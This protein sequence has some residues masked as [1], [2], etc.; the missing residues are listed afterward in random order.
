MASNLFEE[1]VPHLEVT[2]ARVL[3]SRVPNESTKS[4]NPQCN[5]PVL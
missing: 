3:Q 4:E 2:A 5:V 1:E